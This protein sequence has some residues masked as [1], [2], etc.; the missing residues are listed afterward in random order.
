V[1]ILSLDF[2]HIFTSLLIKIGARPLQNGKT[3]PVAIDLTRFL[4]KR[5]PQHPQPQDRGEIA[6]QTR[7]EGLTR[8][9]HSIVT[10]KR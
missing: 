4:P 6:D 10:G 2:N 7:F 9:K 1:R 8:E 3:P 5:L